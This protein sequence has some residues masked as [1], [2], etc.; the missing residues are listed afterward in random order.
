M[1]WEGRRILV[2]SLVVLERDLRERREGDVG[3]RNESRRLG[4]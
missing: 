2:Q 4:N 3:A 1:V